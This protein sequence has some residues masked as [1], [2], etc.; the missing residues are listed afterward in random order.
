MSN[1]QVAAMSYFPP[2]MDL[3]YNPTTGTQNLSGLLD[4]FLADSTNGRPP[5]GYNP[6]NIPP[7]PTVQP[8]P[9]ILQHQQPAFRKALYDDLFLYEFHDTTQ[10]HL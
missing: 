6:L 3:G 9:T 5:P 7:G 4:V 1:P 8:D 10:R 2:A